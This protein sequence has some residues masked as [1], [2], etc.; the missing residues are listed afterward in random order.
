VIHILYMYDQSP[1]N[2]EEKNAILR[3]CGR[4]CRKSPRNFAIIQI[5]QWFDLVAS[6]RNISRLPSPINSESRLGASGPRVRPSGK[7]T[8]VVKRGMRG[9]QRQL[10]ENFAANRWPSIRQ[11]VAS[12]SPHTRRAHYQDVS[13]SHK[14][15]LELARERER[16]MRPSVCRATESS[17]FHLNFLIARHVLEAAIK[18][19]Y[20]RNKRP[21][22]RPIYNASMAE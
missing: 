6:Q 9:D 14:H 13:P 21:F 19:F 4:V 20:W 3:P 22:L 1:A 10:G 18:H 8:R 12:P 7:H 16:E 15:S 11:K 2:K 17:A 5:A